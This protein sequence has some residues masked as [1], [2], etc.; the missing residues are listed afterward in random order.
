MAGKG[1]KPRP[2]NV[3]KEE[4]DKSFENIFGKYV[5]P[6]LRNKVEEDIPVLENEEMWSQRVIDENSKDK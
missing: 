5:P 4:F 2:F 6:Y 1:S 3:P